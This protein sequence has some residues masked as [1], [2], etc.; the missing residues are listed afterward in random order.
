MGAITLGFYLLVLAENFRYPAW[1]ISALFCFNACMLIVPTF[2]ARHGK[3]RPK[4][5]LKIN[6]VVLGALLLVNPSIAIALAPELKS[7]LWA[8]ASATYMLYCGIYAEEPWRCRA[9]ALFPALTSCAH[10]AIRAWR[11][12]SMASWFEDLA[13]GFLMSVFFAMFGGFLGALSSSRELPGLEK[14]EQVAVEEYLAGFGLSPREREVCIA[15]L[16]GLTAK[17]TGE[18]LFISEGTVKIHMK[19]A[20][21]KLG[22]RSKLQLAH[23]VQERNR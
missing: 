14:A 16:E 7:V 1:F 21:R 9:A 13:F 18:R 11:A 6:S 3:M 5:L 10:V 17:E 19:K 22:V 15:L 12:E 23:L 8:L 4:S 2:L 20:Y